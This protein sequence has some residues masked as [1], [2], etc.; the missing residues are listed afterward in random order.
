MKKKLLA[1]APVLALIVSC[2]GE[3]NKLS[4][5]MAQVSVC[6]P[7]INDGDSLVLLAASAGMISPLDTAVA[8][9][10]TATL[11]TRVGQS[12]SL[13]FVLKVVNGQF[14]D[15][16]YPVI[17]EP[18]KEIVMRLPE[19]ND[20]QV[21][22]ENSKN[23]ELWYE[24]QRKGESVVDQL[25]GC[26]AD[27]RNPDASAEERRSAELKVDSAQKELMRFYSAKIIDNAPSA[28][29]DIL[30][31][32]CT[33]AFDDSTLAVIMDKL[34][35]YE[36]QMPNY[37]VLKMSVEAKERSSVGKQFVDFSMMSLD[38][39]MVK[40][41]DV[42]KAN[43]LTLVDFWASWCGPCRAEMPVVVKAFET[44]GG[45]GFSVVGISL[46]TDAAAWTDAVNKL[47]MKWLQLSDLRGWQSQAA[48]LYS[49][50]AIPSCFLIDSEGV[51]VAKNLRGD[52]L[53]EKVGELLR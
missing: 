7:K 29:S 53:L 40:L 2:S 20:G 52:E 33:D 4:A 35:S 6:G 41:S 25:Q 16:V 27:L 17:L 3:T 26:I 32:S 23:S 10:N 49:V 45:K 12:G 21:S 22:F 46:D 28:F 5:D 14:S 44:Y 15:E 30:L 50:D 34:S 36:D 38:G 18:A 8:D 24:C 9:G 43:K 37:K 39:K 47:G 11:Q 51:I 31:G 48:Q 1:I 13:L 42:V 19:A